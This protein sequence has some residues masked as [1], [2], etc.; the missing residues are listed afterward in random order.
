MAH[1]PV[2]VLWIARYDYRPGWGLRLHHHNYFQMI[3]FLDGK[4][5]LT[6]AE[7]EFPIS[8]GALFLLRSGDPHALRA[9]SLVRT[10]DVKFRVA[11]G[12]LAR[13]LRRA[14]RMLEWNEPGI[15]ARLERIRTEGEQKAPWYRDLCSVLLTELLY[16]YL[17]RNP[18]GVPLNDPAMAAQ[19]AAQDPVLERALAHIR[20]HYH[21]PL[22]IRE[23]AHAAGCTDRTLRLHFHAALQVRPL[24]FLQRHRIA[25]AKALIQY[26]ACN[27]KEIAEQVGFQTVHHFT[28][29]FSAMEGRSPA[30]WRREYQAGIRKNVYINPQFE[31]RIF[32]VGAEAD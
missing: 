1:F 5:V 8:S 13:S 30:V 27:L 10:L 21:R 20:A 12:P 17:R 28:R 29:L 6:V 2:D 16:L 24:S 15:A 25:Q 14:P 4:G 19:L 7:Q 22:T 9:D 26:S 31:N 23:I 11:P 3:L 32:T 18:H